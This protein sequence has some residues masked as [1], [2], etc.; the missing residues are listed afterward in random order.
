M[1]NNI[2]KHGDDTLALYFLAWQ[3]VI[4]RLDTIILEIRHIQQNIIHL[5]HVPELYEPLRHEEDYLWKY[6]RWGDK[7]E[8]RNKIQ[9]VK[10]WI[11]DYPPISREVTPSQKDPAGHRQ[12]V[13]NPEDKVRKA[14]EIFTRIQAIVQDC[15]DYELWSVDQKARYHNLAALQTLKQN[16]FNDKLALCEIACPLFS[17]II[18]T[19]QSATNRKYDLANFIFTRTAIMA[20]SREYI[21]RLGD[22]QTN[23]SHS[24][25]F[26]L[27][28]HPRPNINRR[29]DQH[30]YGVHLNN[31]CKGYKSR[32][33][34]VADQAGSM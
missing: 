6:D 4:E 1:P 12:R 20:R 7:T 11:N 33:A 30:M 13:A 25:D 27:H 17:H 34:F 22:L 19:G 2:K 14:D 18:E 23:F 26:G 29:R 15:V 24:Q 8:Q 16:V 32:N 9:L 28:D 3:D 31:R 21:N 10:S 5:L